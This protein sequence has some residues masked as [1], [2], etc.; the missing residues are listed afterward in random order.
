MNREQQAF[1]RW[2]THDPGQDPWQCPYENPGCT[3]DEPCQQC[4]A[5]IGE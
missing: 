3:E 5:D 1:D 4:L 2:L